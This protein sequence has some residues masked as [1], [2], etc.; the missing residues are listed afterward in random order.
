MIA[1]QSLLADRLAPA[2]TWLMIS[3]VIVAAG[4]ALALRPAD[5][6][7]FDPGDVVSY[8]EDRVGRPWR[9]ISEVEFGRFEIRNGRVVAIADFS[10][11]TAYRGLSRAATVEMAGRNRQASLLAIRSR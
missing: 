8:T 6:D 5:G 11:L 1:A 10:E 9:V 3:A 2:A 7:D 4:A